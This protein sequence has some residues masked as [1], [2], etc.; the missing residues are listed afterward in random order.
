M[1]EKI[2]ENIPR[3]A[4]ELKS[5]LNSEEKKI[6]RSTLKLVQEWLE[7]DLEEKADDLDKEKISVYYRIAWLISVAGRWP[8]EISDYEKILIHDLDKA[9]YNWSQIGFVFNREPALI[10]K[11]LLEPVPE[12]V[13]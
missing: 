12:K 13:E 3:K 6:A 4:L 11:V 7:E 2:S 10:E 5:E 8:L 9:G 1:V